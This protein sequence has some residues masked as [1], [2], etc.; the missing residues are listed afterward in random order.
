MKAIWKK[1]F[2]PITILLLIG[3]TACSNTVPEDT[4]AKEL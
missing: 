1:L 2:L 3:T 4:E